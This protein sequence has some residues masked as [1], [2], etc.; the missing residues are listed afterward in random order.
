MLMML[1]MSKNRCYFN[2]EDADNP[3]DLGVFSDKAMC[4]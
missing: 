4:C 1:M 2:K 3:M